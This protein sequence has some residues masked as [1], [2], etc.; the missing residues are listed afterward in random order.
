MT[1]GRDYQ[2][3]RRGLP[4]VPVLE[5]DLRTVFGRDPGAVLG[6]VRAYRPASFLV[7]SCH[8]ASSIATRAY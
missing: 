3:R 1:N 7:A 5:V 6:R 8:L 4:C 2:R